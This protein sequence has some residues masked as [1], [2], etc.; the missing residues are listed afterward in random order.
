MT[1]TFNGLLFFPIT[2]FLGNG[3]VDLA[4]LAAHIERGID[5]GAGGVFA[6]SAALRVRL[7]RAWRSKASSP[8]TRQHKS[9]NPVI[10]PMAISL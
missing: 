10:L 3:E 4:E 5:A 8:D 1:P 2:P 6:A 9:L 7:S